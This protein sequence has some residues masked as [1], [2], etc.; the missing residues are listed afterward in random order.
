MK[1]YPDIERRIAETY[2]NDVVMEL[3]ERTILTNIAETGMAKF[4]KAHSIIDLPYK[5]E[6][7]TTE[8]RLVVFE[9][10]DKIQSCDVDED[11]IFLGVVHS[12]RYIVI[13]KNGTVGMIL[14]APPVRVVAEPE[15]VAEETEEETE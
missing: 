13:P 3:N 8:R 12:E 10:G 1:T 4:K 15:E 6:D 9:K 5:K 11:V 14:T 2:D 7:G